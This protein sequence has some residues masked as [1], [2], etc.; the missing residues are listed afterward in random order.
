M[1]VCLAT[2]PQIQFCILGQPV[3]TSSQC[4][5]SLLM[6]WSMNEWEENP[7]LINWEPGCHNCLQWPVRLREALRPW[8]YSGYIPIFFVTWLQNQLFCQLTLEKFSKFLSKKI[9]LWVTSFASF[10]KLLT[11]IFSSPFNYDQR[12]KVVATAP[13]LV[14]PCHRCLELLNTTSGNLYDVRR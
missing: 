13:G 4:C 7:E 14:L 11:G 5:S 1:S 10:I 6:G 8:A 12:G 3:C 9:N 2:N